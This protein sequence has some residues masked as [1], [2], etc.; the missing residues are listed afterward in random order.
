MKTTISCLSVLVSV[1]LL[2]QIHFQNTTD[3]LIGEPHFSGS[4]IGI[5]D[6]NEDGL[7]DL[8]RLADGKSLSICFQTGPGKSFKIIDYGPV[9]PYQI[10]NT[11]IADIDH[12]GYND[13]VFAANENKAYIYYGSFVNGSM[14]YT[15]EAIDSSETAYAQ[16]GNLIDINKDG[17]LDYFLCNDIGANLIWAGNNQGKINGNPVK[18]ID[19]RT[20]PVS[21]NSGNYGST[22]NDFDNDGDLDLY[23]AKCKSSATSSS[24]PRRINAFFKNNG[25]LQFIETAGENGL[26]S[27]AQSWVAVAGD[28]D[29]DG[30]MDIFVI[31]HFSPSELFI[32]DGTGKFSNKIESS[33]INYSAIGVQAAWADLDNDGWQDLIISG[34]QHQ[35]YKNKGSNKFELINS[36]ELGLYQIES[37]AIG[38]LNNDGRQDIYASYSQIFNQASHRPDAVFLNSTSS[39]NHFIK[40]RLEGVE[41]N[42]SAIGARINL[43]AGGIKQMREIHSGYSYGVH[44]SLTQHFGIGKA[45]K[46]DSVVI[47]WPSGFN[48]KI[49]G[50]FIDRTLVIKENKCFGF[51]PFITSI[52]SK[53]VICATG[54]SFR[55]T[56]PLVGTSYSWSNGATAKDI[57]IKSAGD[58]Q[59]KLVT[60]TG[61]TLFSNEVSIV[62]DPKSRYK[63]EYTDTVICNGSA[64]TL[65]IGSPF[66]LKWNTGD[67][68]TVIKVDKPGKYYAIT[69]NDCSTSMS[70]TIQIRT[71]NPKVVKAQNDTVGLST[72]AI[73]RAEGLSLFWFAESQ[74]GSSIG[75]GNSYQTNP[76]SKSTT[77][78]VQS[79][80]LE[81]GKEFSGGVKNFAGPTKL[82]ANS[83]SGAMFF[84]A[85]ADCVLKSVKVYT[86]TAG[87]REINLVSSDGKIVHTKILRIEKGQTTIPLDFYIPAGL[88]Y[89]LTTNDEATIK[90]FGFK[91]PLLYRTEGTI[92][93]P[94]VSGPLNI[95]GTNA[96]QANYYYFYD[97]QLA[98]PDLECKSERVPVQAVLKTVALREDPFQH[99]WS[100]YPNPANQFL[101]IHLDKSFFP[102]P[103]RYEI[104]NFD[105]KV[106]Q[107][108]FISSVHKLELSTYPCGMYALRIWEGDQ[109]SIK[110]FIKL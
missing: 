6:M 51:D 43:Y 99:K 108:G 74:G 77:F 90:V 67:T 2:A 87:T 41:S 82:H 49:V 30:D 110:K 11:A 40:I 19:F 7:D 93:Y 92:P 57:T 32:N 27:G 100:L 24:D 55:L 29:N 31:N 73:L 23:I 21:D 89:K 66:K 38:D 10:W 85:T 68:A 44:H 103:V 60:A 13:M 5:S 48:E 78:Y 50:P 105:A 101:S 9:S 79:V 54:D 18:W 39:Q 80:L 14:Q 4:V 56:I 34:S 109:S 83:F 25:N 28:P 22:W 42:R 52:P 104:I 36:K 3:Q 65:A 88:G 81:K 45:T 106:V 63:I 20:S 1:N 102:N 16:A 53:N 17:W 64:S 61:C 69:E 76:L 12:N 33:G 71:I 47:R 107:K 98:Y 58:Y 37:F 35:I 97:W 84:D 26:A 72:K 70:D 59:V 15:A 86:D 62:N 95:Y 75:T 91:S 96:G 46:I 94:L 8:V